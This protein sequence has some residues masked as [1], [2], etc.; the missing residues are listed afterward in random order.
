MT[1]NLARLGVAALAAV[2]LNL[3]PETASATDYTTLRTIRVTKL[4][5]PRYAPRSEAQAVLNTLSHSAFYFVHDGSLYF[6]PNYPF[7]TTRAYGPGYWY[8]SG[9]DLYDFAIGSGFRGRL[10]FLADGTPVGIVVWTLGYGRTARTYVAY[11]TLAES[12]LLYG[13][14]ASQ[15]QGGPEAK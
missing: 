7:N 1:A 11:L 4:Y 10:G 5:M 15:A 2:L 6:V 9:Y 3:T 8:Q 12:H 13:S 14:A